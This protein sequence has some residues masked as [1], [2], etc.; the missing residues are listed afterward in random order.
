MVSNSA[1]GGN[2]V[3][4]VGWK[5]YILDSFLIL[6][7]KIVIFVWNNIYNYI[8]KEMRVLLK[9]NVLVCKVTNQLFEFFIWVIVVV[10]LHSGGIK[11]DAEGHF[12]DFLKKK[13]LF[14]ILEIL[15]DDTKMWFGK[16]VKK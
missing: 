16:N 11:I 15:K 4:T 14:Y 13:I 9:E 1:D 3:T 5:K 7:F 2:M 12:L 10:S 8:I 6:S